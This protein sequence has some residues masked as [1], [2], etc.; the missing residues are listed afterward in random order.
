MAKKGEIN[1]GDFG[2]NVYFVG[3]PKQGSG[4]RKQPDY[5]KFLDLT[6]SHIN[7][8]GFRCTDFIVTLTDKHRSIKFI[9]EKQTPYD[10][11]ILGFIRLDSGVLSNKPLQEYLGIDR[12]EKFH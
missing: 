10:E 3:N 11:F 12:L 2:V 7:F 1:G 4:R 6:S 5:I 9:Q 8:G